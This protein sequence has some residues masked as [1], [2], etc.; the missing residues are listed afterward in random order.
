MQAWELKPCDLE[1]GER[2]G[3][4]SFG[5]VYKVQARGHLFAAKRAE[6][7]GEPE[8]DAKALKITKEFRVLHKM[9]HR[10]IVQLVGV[11]MKENEWI[12]LVMELADLGSLRAF[13]DNTPEAVVGKP[14]TQLALAHDIAK[15]MAYVHTE[16]APMLHHDIKSA[17]IL[18]ATS[19]T[20]CRLVAKG[21]ALGL[22]L[23]T[24]GLSRTVLAAAHPED[25]RV[26]SP[27]SP[28]SASPPA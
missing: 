7:T 1:W 19:D 12:C 15:G 10:N 14:A 9:N 25:D 22:D 23:T 27:Q 2:L 26:A 5:V 8:H 11:V 21:A 28:T 18:L 16:H 17:N 20:G 6:L 4:G 24:H 3:A 13:L